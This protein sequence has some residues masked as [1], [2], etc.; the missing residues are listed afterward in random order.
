MD[1]GQLPQLVA[2]SA[3]ILAFVYITAIVVLS[4]VL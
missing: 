1:K 2:R 3:L 4:F